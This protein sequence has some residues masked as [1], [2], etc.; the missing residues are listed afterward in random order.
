MEETRFCVYPDDDWGDKLDE[1]KSYLGIYFSKFSIP[2]S[3]QEQSYVALSTMESDYTSL[4]SLE[5]YFGLDN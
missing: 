4:T 2:W 5:S 3:S 1:Y